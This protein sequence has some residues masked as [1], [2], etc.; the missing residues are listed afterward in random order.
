[1]Q[2]VQRAAA[3]LTNLLNVRFEVDADGAPDVPSSTASHPQ[4]PYDP[5]YVE[6]ARAR[7]GKLP[8]DFPPDPSSAG[9]WSL[10]TALERVLPHFERHNHDDTTEPSTPRPA[11]EALLD[12]RHLARSLAD[13]ASDRLNELRD[14]TPDRRKISA[15][16]SCDGNLSADVIVTLD[17][18]KSANHAL[19]LDLVPIYEELFDT[20]LG[21]SRKSPSGTGLG[22]RPSGP[23]LRFFKFVYDRLDAPAK[24]RKDETILDWVKDW[25]AGREAKA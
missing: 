4:M 1:M 7:G 15:R 19:F 23:A 3:K 24:G 9:A 13:G 8:E 10:P 25:K 11:E 17:E 6:A 5:A 16:Q 22:N 20:A 14:R 12:L 21:S 2:A 18:G